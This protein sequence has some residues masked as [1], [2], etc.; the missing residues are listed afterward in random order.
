[1]LLDVLALLLER[2]THL[3]GANR[4]DVVIEFQH[5]FLLECFYAADYVCDKLGYVANLVMPL[6]LRD[7]VIGRNRPVSLWG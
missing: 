2:D 7:R 4:I 3:L 5:V 6:V 1:M